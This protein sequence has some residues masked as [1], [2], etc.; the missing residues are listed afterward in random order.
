MVLWI[1]SDRNGIL[2]S[3]DIEKVTPHYMNKAKKWGRDNIAVADEMGCNIN[4]LQGQSGWV[5]AAGDF[6]CTRFLEKKI[7]PT[8]NSSLTLHTS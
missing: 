1:S 8:L 5:P 2:N 4:E 6:P 7:V 3:T